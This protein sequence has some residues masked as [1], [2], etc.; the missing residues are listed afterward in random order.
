MKEI[1]LTKGYTAIVDDE[2]YERLVS[3]GKWQV[4][5]TRQHV[6]AIHSMNRGRLYM[7]RV[8]LPSP[9]L[10]DHINGDGLDNRRAN[11]R[12]A[13]PAQ[14]SRNMRPMA[15]SRTGFKGVARQPRSRVNPWRA[16]IRLNDRAH[17][18]GVFRTAEAAARAYDAAAT[19]H[20]GEFAHLNF[21]EGNQS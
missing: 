21:P 2:D 20:F 18:L 12:V 1:P 4:N 10:V 14:N 19:E 3:I 5:V 15:S 7:H 9:V 17:W 8:V 13:T 11:L 6:Y 16:Y